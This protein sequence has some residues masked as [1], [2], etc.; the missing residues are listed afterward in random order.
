M[1]IPQ[2]LIR[3][4]RSA[5]STVLAF[6]A[7]CFPGFAQAQAAGIEA[8][9]GWTQ[10]I[11]IAL[12]LVFAAGMLYS[13]VSYIRARGVLLRELNRARPTVAEVKAIAADNGRELP[14]F[15]ILVPARDESAVIENTIDRLRELDYPLERYAIVVICDERE[16]L[17]AL[18]GR[19]QNIADSLATLVNAGLAEPLLYVIEVP[20]WFSGRFGDERRA[21]TRS[22]KGRA[23]NYA[24]GWL[25]DHPRLGGAE[26]LGLLDAD[27]R[28]HRE[29]LRDVAWRRLSQGASLLQG[30]VLQ[31]S[32]FRDVDLVGKAAGVELSFYHLS[33]LARRLQSRRHAPRFLAGTNYFIDLQLMLKAGGWNEAALVEDAELGLRLFLCFGVRAEWLPCAEIEQTPPD[34]RAYLRQRERWA[35]GHLQLVPQIRACALPWTEKTHL[36]GMVLGGVFKAPFDIGFPVLGWMA[37][38][39]G[40]TAGMPEP[41]TWLMVLLLLSSVFVWD[42]FGRGV[43]LLNPLAPNP[44]GRRALIGLRLLFILVMPWLMLVQAWPRLAGFAKHLAGLRSTEWQKTPRTIERLPEPMAPPRVPDGLACPDRDEADTQRFPLPYGR[45]GAPRRQVD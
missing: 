11:V 22:T 26:M 39:A 43:A 33:T 29:V 20:E 37:L 28:L 3:A 17:Q 45:P 38:A 27:G 14:F 32:N 25:R 36:L 8:N 6:A 10:S 4:A 31:I 18:G 5:E 35:C 13:L 15:V 12:M 21:S 23:L 24:L 44:M 34:L 40:W 16:K 41:L 7:I 1:T 30:P 9:N 42:F 2:S 19:T